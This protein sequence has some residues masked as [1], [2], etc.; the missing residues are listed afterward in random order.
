LKKKE[1]RT[2]LEIIATVWLYTTATLGFTIAL[3]GDAFFWIVDTV[4]A[5]SECAKWEGASEYL[6]KGHWTERPW[7]PA[8]PPE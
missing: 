3:P 7:R 4:V 1:V 8:C 6:L 5:S 2:M